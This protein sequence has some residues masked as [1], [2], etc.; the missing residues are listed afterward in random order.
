M[1]VEPLDHFA[2]RHIGPRP[3]D[4]KSML[5]QVGASSL[6]ALIDEAI[7]ASIRLTKPLELPPAESESQYLARLKGIACKNKVFRS[8]I[9]LGYYD[10]LTPSV[11]RRCLFENPGWYTPYTPYQAEI[12]Q[13][14]LESL[15]NFQTMV[16][17]L[18]GMAVA[19]ASLLDEGTAAGEA[20]ALV[21]RVQTRKLSGTAGVFLVSDRCFPQTIEVLRSRAEPLGIELRVGPADQMSFGPAV[22]GALVQYPD[23]AGRVD[24][25]RPFIARA[26][27]AGVLV[28]V[29]TDLLALALITPPGEMGADV[30]F[31]NSQRFGVPLGFGG[32]HAAFFAAKEDHVR[33]LPGR[34]IGV[35]IDAHGKSAYRMSLQTREQHIRREKATSNICT[36]QALLANMAAMYAVYHGPRG[37][38]AIATRLH[39]LARLL[40]RSLRALGFTQENNAY[41][42][43]LRVSGP[44]AAVKAVRAKAEA[45][46]INFRY[47]GEAAVGISL[48]ETATIEDITAIVNVFAVA[49]GKDA[50]A[51]D[52]ASLGDEPA[53]PPALRRTSAYLTHPV[54]NSHHS[55]TEMMR[56]IR[57]LERK[58]IGLD[59]SMIPL[60]SCTMKLNA[61]SEMYP[62][63]WEEFARIHPFA[64][65]DQ[66]HGY[67]QICRELE[68]ALCA[69]TG[70]PATSLQPNSGAQGEFAGLAVIR[71]YHQNRGQ[72]DR[73]VVL[74]P[75]SA[76]GTNPASAVMAGYR[77]VV[78]ATDPHGNVDVRDLEAKAEQHRG[79]LAVLMITYPSTHG[80]FE[81]AIQDICAIVHDHGGQVYMDGANMNAQ[82]GLTSPA[83]IGADVCHINLHKTFAIPHGGG[84]PGMGPISVAKHL[85]PYLPGHPFR[86]VGGTQP[87]APVASAPWGSASILLIS[88]GYIRMLG[89]QGVTDATKY[90]ILNANYIKSRLETHYDVLYTRKGGR[91]AHE[92]IFDLRKFKAKG[93]EEGDVAK[94]LMDYG[95]HA[96]TVSF[97]VPGTLMVEPTESE[98]KAEI[99][100]FCEALIAIR[101]E[102]EDVITGRADAKDNVLKNAPHAATVVAADE[103]PHPYSREQ[104]AFPLPWVRS[105]KFWPP[106]GRIDNPYGDRNLMCVC[107]PMETYA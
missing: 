35:S 66:T 73:N 92:M 3:D 33:H 60:G 102:I 57:S 45:A 75:A 56:Y 34:I 63:S 59:T 15:L 54:F 36:A 81:D 105:H 46:G 9:G 41:F 58:D 55:E 37:I 2:P 10:T 4:L 90:A 97:P 103:W 94:R 107:P 62:V 30:V 31:G 49:A 96:P 95:F 8:F 69:I 71:A 67:E 78:V 101:Q 48:D 72:G 28:A 25:L 98:S 32:P 87:I 86:G 20:M 39:G 27:A 70:L 100:R 12:A 14:R 99:D 26:R 65:A 64:P 13:G 93:I 51:I 19:N 29:A 106:V 44:V 11:I 88:Y 38:R 83:A 52:A 77:V 16:S 21:H 74:I 22:F 61:A 76:H 82:V 47:S 40:D 80:V 18:T 89:A 6:D 43:T 5:D 68:Q 1:N 53:V 42:D 104:A 85:A 17:D 84:G 24:D 23:E 91:V 79:R 7:P 50:P